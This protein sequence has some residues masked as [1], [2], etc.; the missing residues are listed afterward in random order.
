[1]DVWLNSFLLASLLIYCL[2]NPSRSNIIAASFIIGAWQAVSMIVHELNGWFTASTGIRRI[3]HWV[4]LLNILLLP[5][6]VA[7]IIIFIVPVMAMFYIRL[8]Y[9]EIHIKMRRPLDL[10]K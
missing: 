1:M 2:I 6:H 5:F 10:L 4:A 9:R 8:C 3:Y 7:S